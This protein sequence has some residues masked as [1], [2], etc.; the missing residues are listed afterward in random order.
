[1]LIERPIAEPPFVED[2][3]PTFGV[4]IQKLNDINIQSEERVKQFNKNIAD[5][6]EELD[7]HVDAFIA[8]SVTPIDTHIDIRGAAHGENRATVGL[9]KKDNF[10][11]ATVAEQIAYA[12]VNAFVT[13]KGAKASLDANNA[14]FV[15]ED[16]QRNGVFQF[17]S[18]Y[19]PDDY[20]TLLPTAVEPVRYLTPGSRVPILINGDRL[21]LSPQSDNTNYQRQNLFISLPL[22]GESRTRLSEVVNLSARYNGYS[23]NQ[24]GADTSDG[25]VGFFRPLADKKIYNFATTLP[26]P[27]GNRNY[28][29]Y[30][31]FANTIYKGLGV[32]ASLA[33]TTLRIDH[34]FFYVN[35]VETAPTLTELVT[36][37][38]TG[39]F[40]KMGGSGPVVGAVN[41]YHL[42]DLKDFVTLP[43]GATIEP[44]TDYPGVVT[45][46][47]WNAIDYELYLNISVAVLV[48]QGVKNQRL[49]LSFTESIIPGSL[50]AGGSATWKTLG[51]RVKDTLDANLKPNADATFY[52]VNNP[53]DFNNITQSPGVVMHSG[54]LVKSVGTKY[55]VRVKRVKTEHAGIK[56]WM[57]AK[58]KVIDPSQTS[59]A[60]FAPSRHSPFG[61]LPERVIPVA[62][63]AAI[64]QFLVYGLDNGAGLFSWQQL[65]WN[66]GSIISTQTGDN[67][68]GVKLPELSDNVDGLGVMPASVCVGMNKSAVG[69]SWNALAFTS[70]NQYIGKNSISYV[71]K[72]LTVGTDVTV[73]IPSMLSIQAVARGVV[74]RAAV[75]NPTTPA[76]L[77]KPEIQ[78]FG[79][80]ADKA[81]VVISDG[82]NYAE[83]AVAKFTLAAG[84]FTLDFKPTNGVALKPITPA[85]PAPT[86]TNRKSGSGDGVWMR[87][88]DLQILNITTDLMDF[89]LT[90]PFGENYGDIS[91]STTGFRTAT[92]PVIT[93]GRVNTARLYKGIQQIDL[94]E[95][96]LPSLMI[97][98]KGLFQYDPANTAFTSTMLE[99][100]TA[101][102]Y[103]VDPFNIN[104]T[105]WI[106]MPSGGRVVLGG[107]AYILAEEFALKVNPTG[108]TYC[109]L[110]RLGDTLAVAASPVRREVANNEVLFGI[111]VNGVLQQTTDYLVMSNHVVS[112]TRR[113]TAIPAFA[114]D[115]ANGPNQ[116]FTQRDVL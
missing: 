56:D 65:T 31:R 28:I 6:L 116:F 100:G 36:G 110:M 66:A 49:V 50:V 83:A 99:V 78:I 81:L 106:R 46:M 71:N 61:P 24:V 74:D 97:P 85:A 80:T 73:A 41:G 79:V 93:P 53:F 52:T 92:F 17:A 63:T 84:V 3:E 27:A 9:S 10:R 55:G 13:P 69:V 62:S 20:P 8:A 91:F 39:L 42:Y 101:G 40:D 75:L 35:A 68:F 95:E 114:D 7:S 87:Y 54:M 45:T 76:I 38:Y 104:E 14:D 43:A 103:K 48:K 60:L 107:K 12:N 57:L 51:S 19:Y 47:V 98:A 109:Y 102:V 113:G 112:A 2:P 11:T 33:N 16:Y 105:G 96:V 82:V 44:D 29:L 86:G 21:I 111:A 77:R 23:W 18:Y 64:T 5:K 15:L 89:V 58:R 59:T 70:A 108:T 37:A 26:L 90:R 94:A 30:N 25:K 4:V 88:A 1:M 32:T 72:V 22:K 115:G 67:V 34:R